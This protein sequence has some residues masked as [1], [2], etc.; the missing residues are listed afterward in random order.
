[1][2]SLALFSIYNISVW[3]Q[4]VHTPFHAQR[5]AFFHGRIYVPVPVKLVTGDSTCW[6]NV[7]L[8][9]TKAGVPDST[10]WSS[11]SSNMNDIEFMKG[12][13]SSIASFKHAPPCPYGTRSAEVLGSERT[14]LLS[15]SSNNVIVEFIMD[16][17]LAMVLQLDRN[18][19]YQFVSGM[20]RIPLFS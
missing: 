4:I 1:M 5:R 15:S 13:S 10:E 9:F 18:L 16:H 6:D 17:P 7:G 14:E 8:W 12:S 2:N 20:H 3:A 11:S 19:W